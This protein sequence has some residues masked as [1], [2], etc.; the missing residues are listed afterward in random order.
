MSCRVVVTI[1]H[2]HH[3]AG[4][5]FSLR[6]DLT[7]PG[8]EIAVNRESN[9]H[10]S[11]KDLGEQDWVKQFEVEGMRKDLKLVIREAFDVARR[12]IQDYARKRR[13]EVKT[14]VEM[15]RGRVIAWIPEAHCG[16]I[17]AP[18][19]HELYFHENSVLGTGLKRLRV[20]AEV[21]FVEERGEK[22]P[23]ASSVQVPRPRPEHASA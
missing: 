6:I 20:G 15:P 10:A 22:G 21:V 19:G 16:A 12:R 17:Q 14:H 13:L 2:R 23:Q 5:R 8:G 11:R 7:V 18:D 1:P 9:L 4:N 3:E